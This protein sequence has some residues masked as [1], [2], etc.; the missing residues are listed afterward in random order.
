MNGNFMASIMGVAAAM[1]L[2]ACASKPTGSTERLSAEA[3]AD[4]ELAA[5]YQSLIDNAMGLTSCR[6]REVTGSRLQREV[7]ITRAQRDAQH[8]RALEL[9]H[10]IQAR[11]TEVPQQMPDQSPGSASA[12]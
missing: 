12:P 1:A 5:E 8:D 11:S 3:R 7:C 9:L 6:Q 4:Q 2:V 10:D